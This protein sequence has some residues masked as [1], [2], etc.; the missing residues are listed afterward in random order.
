MS[1]FYTDASL[2]MIPSGYKDQKVYCAKPVD[3]SADLTFSRASNA[4]RVNS[5][6]LVEKVR[7]NLQTYSQNFTSAGGWGGDPITATAN[8]GTAPDGTQT[9]TRLVFSSANHVWQ[10]SIT[11]INGNIGVFSLYIKGTA[12]E[13][14]Q[15][16]Y[17]G[18]DKLVTIGTGWT[19]VN[20]NGTLASTG[21]ININTYGGNARDFEVWGGQTELGDIA[22][23]YIVTTSAAVSV[24]PV[25]G[26][27]RLDYSGGCPS[28]L[29]EPQRTNLFTYSEQFDNAAW[30]KSATAT[31]IT[32]NST[33]SP[34]GY[35]DADT[36]TINADGARYVGQTKTVTAGAVTA[37]FFVKKGTSNWFYL[38]IED[39]A[40]FAGYTFNV[41]TGQLGQSVSSGLTPTASIV[42]YANGWYRCIVTTTVSG[43]SI[44][45]A[46]FVATSASTISGTVGAS[47]ICWGAQFEQGA[48]STSYINTLSSAVTRVADAASKTGISSLIGQTE[49]TLFFDVTL[50]QRATYTYFVIAPNLGSA[51]AYIGISMEAA[52]FVAEILN[53]GI[54]ASIAFNNTST[55]RFKGAFAY[56]ANDVAFYVNGNLVGTDTSATIPACSQFA[57]NNYDKEAAPK[58]NQALLFKTRLSNADLATLTTL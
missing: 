26:L 30:T 13:T 6:G 56:K 40:N 44:L 51:T 41:A 32:A 14:I 17:G 12:G 48:F 4:T 10:K 50:D 38:R 15:I 9:S 24:G 31:T 25:S 54:Q 22:T 1:S 37:S 2:V 27:P 20:T 49:G 29:L 8:Y 35:Q 36:W 55:G 16:A 21:T 58:Y 57:L 5:S 39:G 43:T 46:G 28:L 52:R 34:S 18:T 33:I 23:D 19:R 7:T 45:A 3:G 42:D 53:S 47:L 11:G